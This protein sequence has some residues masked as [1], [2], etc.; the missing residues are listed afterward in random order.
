M[1]KRVKT[2][3]QVDLEELQSGKRAKSIT[4]Q[5]KIKELKP[6]VLET[7][8]YVFVILFLSAG[9]YWRNNIWNSEVELWTDCV[10]KSSNKERPHT[11]LGSALGLQGR[12]QEAIAQYTEALRINP[13]YAEA[14]YNLGNALDHLGKYQEAIAQYTEAL[15]I[16]PNYAEAH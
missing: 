2:I 3:K 15:R 10:K 1:A 12:H 4:M 5:G 6:Y 9:T 14:H 8:I 7:L 16:N 13:N 11:N